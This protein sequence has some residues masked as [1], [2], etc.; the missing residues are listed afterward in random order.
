MKLT[1]TLYRR[2]VLALSAI[3][4][5][6]VTG[7][8]ASQSVVQL[9]GVSTN[10]CTYS[11][12]TVTPNG[13]VVVTCAGST[14][15]AT[16]SLSAPSTL[17]VSTTTSTQVNIVRSGTASAAQ[18]VNYQISGSGCPADGGT[19]SF[20]AGASTQQAI[21]FTTGSTAGQTCVV[22]ITP[23]A[24]SA[25]SPT[26]KTI[27]LVDPNADVQFSF[28]ALSSSANVGTSADFIQVTRTGGTAGAYTVPV[29]L[30]GQGGITI[31]GSVS[32]NTL[33]F[34]ANGTTTSVN[35]SYV[36]PTATPS[37]PALPATMVLT[38]GTPVVVGTP[39]PGQTPTIGPNATHQ[40][41]LNGPPVGCPV[42]DLTALQ[43]GTAGT[44][45]VL[46][47]ISGIAQSYILPTATN[48]SKNLTGVG[49]VDLYQ[50]P[51]T[52]TK[53]VVRSEISISKCRGDFT[54]RG[55][56][57]YKSS[58]SYSQ[59]GPVTW[60]DK[61]NATYTTLALVKQYQRCW[62][63]VSEGPWYYNVRITYETGACDSDIAKWT[64]CGWQ[65]I[66]KS[67]TR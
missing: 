49:R 12:M 2:T 11:A 51:Y 13:N 17:P 23:P 34:P 46:R 21:S 58:G 42:T 43:P 8:A 24:G 9:Q 63:P 50:A 47:G 64:T 7:Y 62:A 35:V 60:M 56:F 53:G 37:D 66:W 32:P 36:P 28:A 26:S 59:V 33:S 39:P 45:N 18:D 29:T 15:A 3:A 16:Y 25:G 5:L 1:T 27:T 52:P 14:A 48:P 31:A 40:I 20:S 10:Q 61:L 22:A 57:C 38:L 19:V 6:T 30:T 41:T 67:L 54:D 4:A 65:P 44:V 55:D